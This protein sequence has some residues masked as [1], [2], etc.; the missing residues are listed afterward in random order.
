ME[1][2]TNQYNKSF[3]ELFNETCKMY[4]NSIAVILNEKKITYNKLDERA[5][6]ISNEL[7]RHGVTYGS[8]IGLLLGRSID[9]V[10]V[11]IGILRVGAAFLPIDKEFPDERI[12][13]ILTNSNCN[14]LI[15]DEKVSRNIEFKGTVLNINDF[16][17]ES[18]V[19]LPEKKINMNDLVYV[20]YTSGSTGYPKGVM[21]SHRALNAFIY[22]ICNEINLLPEKRILAVTTISF[23]ISI[24]ELIVPLIKGMTIV[25]AD[26]KTIRNSRLLTQYIKNNQINIVQMTPTRMDLLLEAS[27]SFEWMDS[28]TEVLIGGEEFPMFLLEKLQKFQNIQIFNLYGPTEATIWISCCELT[29]KKRV[30]IGK[31]FG[32]NKMYILNEEYK[33]VERGSIGEICIGGPQ[34]AEGYWAN[35]ELTDSKFINGDEKLYK[36]GDIGRIDKEGNFECLGRGDNQVKIRGY[37]VEINEVENIFQ[38]Y[39]KIKRVIVVPKKGK[40][41]NTYLCAYYISE[42]NLSVQEIRKFLN[43]YLANYMIPDEFVRVEQF[44]E[45]LNHK[46][47][48]IELSRR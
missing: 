4:P 17:F 7:L 40:K 28:L 38:R 12:K 18:C 9:I 16:S 2:L 23:D 3:V 34:L 21:I 13:Y 36:T 45:T 26:E 33:E 43:R 47:D 11:M 1:K 8:I 42:Q 31:P 37:L 27:K 25:L 32:K 29:K 10:A 30:S 15:V 20:I 44:P 5:N 24:L 39:H 22:G 6:A 46:I 14:V 35:R 48:K 19:K 41:M